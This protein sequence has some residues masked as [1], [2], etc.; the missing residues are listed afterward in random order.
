MDPT[1]QL[2]VLSFLPFLVRATGHGECV[3][4]GRQREV[5]AHAWQLQGTTD[6]SALVLLI[7]SRTGGRRR[8]GLAAGCTRPMVRG[9]APDSKAKALFLYKCTH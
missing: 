3:P 4:P 2:F 5:A 9:S 7:L 1:H 6:G 8:E